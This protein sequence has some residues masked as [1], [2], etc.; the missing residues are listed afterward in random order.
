MTDV[1]TTYD[2]ATRAYD[3]DHERGLI[4]A[5]TRTIFE[6]SAVSDADQ[7]FHLSRSR[8]GSGIG[9]GDGKRADRFAD[10]GDLPWR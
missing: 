1:Q 8:Q 9:Q 7:P 4:E 2:R 10:G 3:K 6:T 5:I